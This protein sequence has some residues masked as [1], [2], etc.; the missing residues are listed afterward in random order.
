MRTSEGGNVDDKRISFRSFCDEEQTTAFA[1]GRGGG[2]ISYA[3]VAVDH[4]DGQRRG[5]GKGRFYTA[6]NAAPFSLLACLDERAGLIAEIAALSAAAAKLTS[7]A[8]DGWPG[9]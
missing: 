3:L 6:R 5:T 2:P 1:R 7:A 9:R 4:D 8:D